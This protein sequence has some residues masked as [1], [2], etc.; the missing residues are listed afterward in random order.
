MTIRLNP[1]SIED[2]KL[3]KLQLLNHVQMPPQSLPTFK[4][5]GK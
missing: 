2:V 5:S 3:K 4:N 1:L